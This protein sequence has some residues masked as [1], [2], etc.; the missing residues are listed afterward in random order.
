MP[1]L[2]AI[3]E[4]GLVL[5]GDSEG[6]VSVW[7]AASFGVKAQRPRL[8]F[9]CSQILNASEQTSGLGNG[10]HPSKVAVR[11]L[12]YRTV[13]D[14]KCLLV[15]ATNN[16]IFEV[17][18]EDLDKEATSDNV[19]MSRLISQGH[20]A[21]NASGDPLTYHFC[22]FVSSSTSILYFTLCLSR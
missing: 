13:P 14:A 2:Q 20:S 9:T 21:S 16:L 4:H 8:S 5:T 12:G 15:G 19:V 11:S 3:A 18:F 1:H 6:T 17:G 7:S 22:F 10:T